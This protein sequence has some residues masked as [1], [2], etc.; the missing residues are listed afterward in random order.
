VILVWFS[1]FIVASS[2]SVYTILILV[3]GTVCSSV[4]LI[5]VSS[6]LILLDVGK[7]PFDYPESES[8][9][10]TGYSVELQDYVHHHLLI[11]YSE[12]VVL[13]ILMVWLWAGCVIL[14]SLSSLLLVFIGCLMYP[15]LL[16]PRVRIDYAIRLLL[17]VWLWYGYDL[18]VF[19]VVTID[20]D[21]GLRLLQSY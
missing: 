11:E 3:I 10:V 14:L 9:L 13:V 18:G 5:L 2:T 4:G 1:F 17:G 6:C 19:S 15:R 8:E 16:I 7:V 20:V 12:Y 21:V